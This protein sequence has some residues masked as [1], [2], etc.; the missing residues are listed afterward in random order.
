M[1]SKVVE[2]LFVALLVLPETLFKIGIWLNLGF[3]I[4]KIPFDTQLTDF[5]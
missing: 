2:P 1:Q 5:V 3:K 4:S